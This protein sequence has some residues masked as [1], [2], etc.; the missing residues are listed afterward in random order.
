M[1]VRIRK[2]EA[3]NET[4]YETKIVTRD[5]AFFA[6]LE[7]SYASKKFLALNVSI[8]CDEC[9][10]ILSEFDIDLELLREAFATERPPGP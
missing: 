9:Q 7:S 4:L 10:H 8:E 3:D 5:T 1:K 6:V 2:Y